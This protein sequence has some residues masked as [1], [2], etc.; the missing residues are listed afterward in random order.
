MAIADIAKNDLE[1]AELQERFEKKYGKYFT[2]PYLKM[3]MEKLL[4]RVML[5]KW[6]KEID[7]RWTNNRME[8]SL[9]RKVPK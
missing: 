2:P 1:F 9:Y 7:P 8:V 3:A 5:P 4:D 6:A